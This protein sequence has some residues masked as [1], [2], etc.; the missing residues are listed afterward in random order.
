MKP[1][2]LK[3]AG[4]VVLVFGGVTSVGVGAIEQDTPTVTV[5]IVMT[6]DDALATPAPMSA[7][8]AIDG[9]PLKDAASHDDDV[10]AAEPQP[11]P[12]PQ[13]EHTADPLSAIAPLDLDAVPV[14]EPVLSAAPIAMPPRIEDAT[15]AA[16]DT[17]AANG[18]PNWPP[19]GTIALTSERLDTMRG[20][21]DLP[22]GLKVSFGIQQVAFVNGNMVTSTNFNIP[23]IS[24]MTAQQAQALASANTSGLVQVGHGN[25]VQ[26][27]ALPGLTGGVIQNTLSNQQIQA[28]T[29]INTTVNSLG[30]FKTF[31]VGST[32]NSA[33]INAVRPR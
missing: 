9:V 27:G 28:L 10:V 12:Q 32:I 16:P 3:L 31:N 24:A 13:P 17:D 18:D 20:G 6:P 26:P 23:D 4:M 29:T 7:D 1:Q 8:S 22:T 14:T 5:G 2:P 21:F 25:T 30:A 33:L 19:P 11:E 15:V